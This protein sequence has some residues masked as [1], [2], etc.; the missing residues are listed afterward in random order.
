MITDASQSSRRKP[1]A[2]LEVTF[3]GKGRKISNHQQDSEERLPDGAL[4]SLSGGQSL[5][6]SREV[7]HR[8]G[9]D[10]SRVEIT[11]A[12]QRSLGQV[13]AGP[14]F[15]GTGLCSGFPLKPRSDAYFVAQEFVAGRADL[16]EALSRALGDFGVQPLCADDD[17]RP[18]HILCKICALIQSTPFGVYHLTSQQNRNVELGIAVTLNRPT[19]LLWNGKEPG[20]QLP[21]F[22]RS[23][24]DRIV[25]FTGMATLKRALE[26]RLPQWIE[27]PPDREWINRTCVFGG[28]SCEFREAHPRMRRWE[29]AKLACHISRGPDADGE[30]FRLWSG[31]SWVCTRAC[32]A[33]ALASCLCPRDSS[34]SCARS[35]RRPLLA[36]E[37]PGNV[38]SC[39]TLSNS[40]SHFA[41]AT[42]W[43]WRNCRTLSATRPRGRCLRRQHQPNGKSWT[44]CA[45]RPKGAGSWK[46]SRG[47]GITGPELPRNLGFPASL[48]TR[49]CGN[50]ASFSRLSKL[51]TLRRRSKKDIL[52]F[53]ARA[54]WSFGRMPRTSRASQGAYAE[55][56]VPRGC[57]PQHQRR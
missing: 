20:V 17:Y 46:P 14:L 4:S 1:R 35:A 48:C 44:N 28:R 43:M 37:W 30:D 9:M 22:L 34:P 16:R 15:S 19:L 53:R 12:I 40:P 7:R 10:R 55:R 8:L 51:G 42:N 38:R 45:N 49:S 41:A 13:A 26:E 29:Q 21:E 31:T 33:H 52:L 47:T 5:A 57:Q 23:L 25:E 6:D 27:A 11:A 50:S 3:A 18:G 2:F 56:E 36:Y 24:R 32:K 54:L 39:A